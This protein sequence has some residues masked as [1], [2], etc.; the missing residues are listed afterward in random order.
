MT[1]AM[2]N[3]EK[4]RSDIEQW[5]LLERKILSPVSELISPGVLDI[6]KIPNAG[7]RFKFRMSVLFGV[8]K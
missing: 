8:W 7:D 1:L 5:I 3:G 6:A 4:F 2:E